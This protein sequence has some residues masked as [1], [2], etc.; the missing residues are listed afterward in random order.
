MLHLHQNLSLIYMKLCNDDIDMVGIFIPFSSTLKQRCRIAT[1]RVKSAFSSVSVN[2]I[3]AGEHS[4][5]HSFTGHDC[6][7]RQ[8]SWVA[9]THIGR[10]EPLVLVPLT[11]TYKRSADPDLEKN[12]SGSKS[13]IL[14]K[15]Y[16]HYNIHEKHFSVLITISYFGTI[17]T[18]VK[19]TQ[20][21]GLI[22]L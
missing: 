19:V 18:Y 17:W 8:Q 6:F 20:S 1:G 11:L 7:H 10:A 15:S 16:K 9:A 3:D 22:S 21:K 5:P 14:S 4:D 12:Y 13:N 2:K